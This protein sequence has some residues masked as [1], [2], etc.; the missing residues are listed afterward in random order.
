[1]F[2]KLFDKIDRQK[3]PFIDGIYYL[4][5]LIFLIIGILILK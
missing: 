2:K 3:Y 5:I 4:F 1:M